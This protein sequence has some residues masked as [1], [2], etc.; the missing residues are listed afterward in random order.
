MYEHSYNTIKNHYA[1]GK[2]N[3]TITP[4]KSLQTPW[5]SSILMLYTLLR[6]SSHIVS[7][8]SVTIV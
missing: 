6:G 1:P 7:E 2:K 8:F 4:L 5:D 3:T